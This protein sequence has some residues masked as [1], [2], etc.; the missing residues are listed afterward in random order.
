VNLLRPELLTPYH[1]H[2]AASF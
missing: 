2:R 1:L